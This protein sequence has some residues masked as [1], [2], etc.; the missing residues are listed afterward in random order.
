VFGSVTWSGVVPPFVGRLGEVRGF[1]RVV[2]SAT[3]TSSF[4]ALLPS[5]ASPVQG[6]AALVRSGCQPSS[7]RLAGR[8]AS[9]DQVIA[10]ARSKVIGR[11]T[12]YQGR[13]EK[14]TRLNT[15]VSAVV[16]EVAASGFSTLSNAR[17]LF[18]RALRRCGV[19]VARRSETVIFHDGL[20]VIA[21]ASITEF[22]V[23]AERG[24]WVYSA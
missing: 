15:P 3:V 8:P 22:I 20:S 10:V 7:V 17:S 11:V 16:M 1:G 24:W 12:H 9:V 6:S 5:A 2:L 19:A 14:R 23:R 21:D 4:A 13:T 18:R